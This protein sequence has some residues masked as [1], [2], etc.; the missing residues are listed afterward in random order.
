LRWAQP[1]LTRHRRLRRIWT[2]STTVWRCITRV[3]VV[4]LSPN[5]S[6]FLKECLTPARRQKLEAYTA[7]KLAFY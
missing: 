5:S 1:S 2:Y 3:T 6:H 4:L 7:K